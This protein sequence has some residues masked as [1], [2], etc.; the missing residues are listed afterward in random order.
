MQQLPSGP[1]GLPIL[2]YLPFLNAKQPHQTLTNLSKIFGTIYSIQ[3]GSIFTVVLS[4]HTLIREAFSKDCFSGR[5]PLFLTHGI[6]HG[7]G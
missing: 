7:K 2:G 5:A 1:W 4:D 6:M 3:L